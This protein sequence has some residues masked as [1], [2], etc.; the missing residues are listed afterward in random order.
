MSTKL[1]KM[2]KDILVKNITII[3]NQMLTNGI[4][5][6]KLKIA[7]IMTVYKKDDETLYTNY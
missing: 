4:F 2:I 7:K 3:I 5:S 1:I 6:D